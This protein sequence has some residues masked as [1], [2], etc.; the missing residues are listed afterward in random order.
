MV[1][2]CMTVNKIIGS[3][4]YEQNVNSYFVNTFDKIEDTCILDINDMTIMEY[5]GNYISINTV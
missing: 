3:G 2:K 4:R 1:H 5:D